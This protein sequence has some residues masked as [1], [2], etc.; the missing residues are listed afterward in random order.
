MSAVLAPVMDRQ[1]DLLEVVF[2]IDPQACERARRV[3][4]AMDMLRS[5][6]HRREVSGAIQ[7]RFGVSQPTA[8]GVVDM[9]L[10]MAGPV[11]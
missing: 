8:W 10:D 4:M 6:S 5:G 11:E 9:A 7:R 3:K 1:P 2:A